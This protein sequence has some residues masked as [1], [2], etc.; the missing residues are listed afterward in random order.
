[1]TVEAVKEE[2]VDKVERLQTNIERER[3][4]HP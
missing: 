4:Q 1:M 2:A 3:R